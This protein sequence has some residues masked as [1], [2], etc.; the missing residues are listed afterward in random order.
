MK[1]KGRRQS[2]NIQFSTNNRTF[3]SLRDM[4]DYIS[5]REEATRHARPTPRPPQ[6]LSTTQVTERLRNSLDRIE[7]R[8]R[9]GKRYR[10]G[11]RF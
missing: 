4:N 2:P 10:T 3:P 5:I 9:Q 1:W 6:G 7:A 11:G 8:M